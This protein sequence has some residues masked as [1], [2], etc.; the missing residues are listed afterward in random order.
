[1][2][3]ATASRLCATPRPLEIL[4][5][6]DGMIQS[7]YPLLLPDPAKRAAYDTVVAWLKATAGQKKIM[8][9]TLRRPLDPSVT[10][11][12]RLLSNVGNA[13]YFPDDQRVI[14]KLLADYADPSLRTPDRVIFAVDY[15]GSMRGERIDALRVTFAGLSGADRSADGKVLPL[16]PWR[17]VHDHPLRWSGSRSA[18]L[19]PQR[20]GRPDSHPNL[21]CLGGVRRQ[22]GH[23]V[24]TG[25]RL[26][27]GSRIPP[28]NPHQRVSIVLTTDGENNAGIG[29]DEF[30]VH[31]SSRD[32]AV[33]TFAI[34]Y[35]EA[36]RTNSSRPPEQLAGSWLTPTRNRC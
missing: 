33:P 35:G 18:R 34:S 29:L 5:P 9:G 28:N 12:P 21:P 6:R 13:L 22:H 10:R 32:P 30:L 1:M 4:Y 24:H 14:D 2:N 3:P 16:L 7:D 23:L 27:I 36:N 20:T 31:T 17:T 25:L 15:S 11:D 8:D 19:H 26:W